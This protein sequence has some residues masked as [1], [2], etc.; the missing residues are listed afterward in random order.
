MKSGAFA[1]AHATG[2]VEDAVMQVREEFGVTAVVHGDIDHGDAGFGERSFEGVMELV[3]TA[4]PDSFGSEGSGVL[5]DVVV[6]KLDTRCA[7]VFEHLLESD[8]VVS[9]VAQDDVCEFQ[10]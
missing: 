5:N 7:P 4:D 9:V 1:S 10:S 2:S 6:A 3:H 8:H